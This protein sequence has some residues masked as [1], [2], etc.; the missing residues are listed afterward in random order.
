MSLACKCPE[1]PGGSDG[2]EKLADGRRVRAVGPHAVWSMHISSTGSSS[3]S[4]L[5]SLPHVGMG[6]AVARS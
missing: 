3:S 2:E 5:L 6:L 1:G 4:G